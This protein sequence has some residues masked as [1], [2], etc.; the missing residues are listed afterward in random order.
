MDNATQ[1]SDPQPEDNATPLSQ[2]KRILSAA[3]LLATGNIIQRLLGMAREIVKANLF[4][5]SG[6]LAAYNLAALVPN[7]FYQLIAGG[8]MIT[9]SLVPVFSDYVAQAKREELW[10]AFSTFLSIV[11]LVLLAAVALIELFAPQ[12]AWLVGADNLQ[13]PELLPLTI[14]LMRWTTPV[15]L[16][17]SISSVITAVLYALQRFTLPAFTIATFNAAI[18]LVAL[19]NQDNIFSL[20]WGMLLG[21]FLMI[22][23]QLPALRDATVRFQLNWRHPVVRRILAL[24]APIVLGLLVNQAGILIGYNLAT[25]TG[26][27]S[28][29]YM[30]YSTTL[31]Q[32]PLGLV[33]MGLSTATLPMLSQQANRNLKAFKETLAQGLRLV[34]ALI[35]PA[36]AGLFALALPIIQLLFL[37]GEFTAQDSFVTS[38]VLRVDLI[39][40]PFAAVDQMLVYASYARKDTLRPALAGVVSV[41]FYIVLAQWLIGP[42]GLLGLMAANASKLVL[43][44]AIMIWLLNY[45]LGGLRGHGVTMIGL[46][47]LTA[48]VATGITALLV[49]QALLT[50][51]EPTTLA[52]KLV[53]VTIPGV[54]GAAV[55]LACA[56][57]LKIE[58]FLSFIHMIQNR[59]NR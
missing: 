10:A 12:V 20:A 16:F 43:H 35:L 6:T 54:I 26:D 30:S 29:T 31:Y 19:L 15:M 4:G 50:F 21:S 48:A 45:Q 17:L 37:H 1:S 42:F 8:E 9:S 34:L 36:A 52:Y 56:W 44:A 7:T 28:V 40:L 5:A 39:G 59:L 14:A 33:V 38:Q 27:E 58:E 3:V 51:I 2:N 57:F 11:T 49:Y 13:D 23:L 53:L 46:K 47:A 32:L 25:R 41:I 24:Y 18:I 22:L 55:Y